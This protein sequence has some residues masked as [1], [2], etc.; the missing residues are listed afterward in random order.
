METMI[1]DKRLENVNKRWGFS[2]GLCVS[3]VKGYSN[4]QIEV[5]VLDNANFPLLREVGVHGWAKTSKKYRTWVLMRSIL[6]NSPLPIVL[7]GDFNE[8][9]SIYMEAD[10]SP[11]TIIKER[12]DRFLAKSSWCSLV[13][14][15]TVTNLH[16]HNSDHG[17][18]Y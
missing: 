3:S 5:E 12:L 9:Q 18:I 16:I 1:N 2:N 13:P 6:N 8:G 14:E 10:N 15:V 17:P 7:F 11:S 4:H